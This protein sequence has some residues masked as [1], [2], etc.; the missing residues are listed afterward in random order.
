MFGNNAFRLRRRAARAARASWSPSITPRLYFSERS[1]ASL[2]DRGKAVLPA[3]P[4]GTLPWKRFCTWP[5]VKTGAVGAELCAAGCAL[6][7]EGLNPW[8]AAGKEHRI[9]SKAAPERRWA[10]NNL[11]D[12]GIIL[13]AFPTLFQI[14]KLL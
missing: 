4:V 12:V 11:C 13:P 1:I 3:S 2:R 7:A 14:S 10:K 6:G 5:A 9:K 8:A